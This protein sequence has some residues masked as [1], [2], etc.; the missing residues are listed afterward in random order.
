MPQLKQAH[1]HTHT[2]SLSKM[3]SLTVYYLGHTSYF[4]YVGSC[5]LGER[6]CHLGPGTKILLEVHRNQLGQLLPFLWVWVFLNN[7]ILF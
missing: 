3:I 2:K 5:I 4:S 7:E 6:S 1:T